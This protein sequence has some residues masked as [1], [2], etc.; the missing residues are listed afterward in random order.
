M[1]GIRRAASGFVLAAVT[2]GA[3]AVSTARAQASGNLQA[4]VTVLDDLVSRS[5]AAQVES[6]AGDWSAPA[7]S[8]AV[9]F[10]LHPR[11]G[12]TATVLELEP[13]DRLRRLRVEIVYLY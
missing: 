9:P 6:L 13:I 2:A 4:S 12:V 10:E 11:Q 5:V 7:G 3:G 8:S 1:T